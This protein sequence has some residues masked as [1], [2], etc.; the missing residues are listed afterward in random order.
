[1]VINFKSLSNVSIKLLDV[2]LLGVEQ[3]KA[4]F[5]VILFLKDL[6]LNV[7]EV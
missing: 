2:K 5:K 6:H 7:F 1:M 4:K 3:A